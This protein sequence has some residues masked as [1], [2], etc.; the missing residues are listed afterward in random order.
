MTEEFQAPEEESTTEAEEYQKPVE[1]AMRAARV[2]SAYLIIARYKLSKEKA[3]N[4]A[5]EHIAARDAAR[6]L[7]PHQ[8]TKGLQHLTGV[9]M[10]HTF[11]SPFFAKLPN[12]FFSLEEKEQTALTQSAIAEVGRETLGLEDEK[13]T[14]LTQSALFELGGEALGIGWIAIIDAHYL[15]TFFQRMGGEHGPFARVFDIEVIEL[16]DDRTTNDIYQLMTPRSW[17]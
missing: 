11:R 6:K 1:N 15:Q 13:Q 12:D 9:R 4:A 16:N 10:I 2:R 17:N 8:N 7:F 3:V 5:D 14:A